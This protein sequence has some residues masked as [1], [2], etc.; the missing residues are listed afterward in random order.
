M[1]LPM[2]AFI[3][4]T[5]T[6]E[7]VIYSHNFETP[8]GLEWSKN[9]ISTTPVGLRSFLGQFGAQSV[10][11]SLG[12]GSPVFPTGLPTHSSVTVSFELFVISSWDSA[13]NSG[14]PDVWELA[15][16]GGPLLRHATF[17][18]TELFGGDNAIQSFPGDY[19]TAVFPAGHGASEVDSLEMGDTTWGPGSRVYRLCFTFSHTADS[20]LLQ[21]A[22][23]GLTDEYWG[24]DNI[25]VTTVD[26]PPPGAAFCFGDGSGAS[27]ACGNYGS[28]CEGCANSGGTGSRLVCEGSASASIDDLHPIAYSLLHNQPALL[29]VGINRVNG[30]DGITFGDGLRCVGGQVVRLGV[31]TPSPTGESSWGPGLAAVGGWVAGDTRGFQVWYRNPRGLPCGSNFNLS[32]AWEVSFLP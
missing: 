4:A 18:N 13:G 2:V 25:R 11:L 24:L 15:V 3:T 19:P 10:S 26:V 21:F 30:G 7:M 16:T 22:G 27:C 9:S 6:M 1:F 12:T 32:N 31:K 29:F 14:G 5:S 20:V 17:S 8:V 28:S 23:L